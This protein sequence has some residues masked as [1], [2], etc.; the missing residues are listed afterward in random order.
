MNLSNVTLV[1]IDCVDIDRCVI[2]IRKSTENITF[3][4][5]VLLTSI[6]TYIDVDVRIIYIDKLIDLY[7]YSK[8]IIRR[9]ADYVNTDFVL[10]IQWDGYVV[11]SSKWTDE[12]LKYDYIGAP[13]S[14]GL[15]G[16]GGFSLRSKKLLDFCKINGNYMIN[17]V[18]KLKNELGTNVYCE[19]AIL[20]DIH[21]NYLSK[22]SFRISP[23]EL[24]KQFSSEYTTYNGEFGWH[25]VGG[26]TPGKV[27]K[28]NPYIKYKIDNNINHYMKFPGG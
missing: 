9:L 25:G 27:I 4:D 13:W 2:P 20:T 21:K 8:F 11:D 5:I 28:S 26:N 16:N 17:S 3:G 23:I 1:I 12:F 19:D 6:R 10:V 7:E 14:N 15:V 18:L 22:N 24:A